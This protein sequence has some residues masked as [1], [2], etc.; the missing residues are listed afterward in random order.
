MFLL[1]K[2]AHSGSATYSW[3]AVLSKLQKAAEVGDADPQAERNNLS[4][5]Y[6]NYS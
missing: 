3:Q 1:D 6:T 4:L 2:A 5:P